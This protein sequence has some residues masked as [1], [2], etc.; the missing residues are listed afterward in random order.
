MVNAFILGHAMDQSGI[1]LVQDDADVEVDLGRLHD[2]RLVTGHQ[3]K[4]ARNFM[5]AN[6]KLRWQIL[7][8]SGNSA[9]TQTIQQWNTGSSIPRI[10]HEYFQTI[11]N[12]SSNTFISRILFL[13]YFRILL[14]C[15]V[16]TNTFELEESISRIL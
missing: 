13:E 5:M 16:F 6:T 4:D 14:V 1:G 3:R 2:K 8:I 9:N 7:E 11:L 10:L 12:C 15:E